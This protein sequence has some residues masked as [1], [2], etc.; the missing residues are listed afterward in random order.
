MAAEFVGVVTVSVVVTAVPEGVTVAGEKL[1]EAPVERSEQPKETAEA[2]PFAGV[3][4]TVVVLL[5]PAATVSAMG[6][7]AKE[8]SGAGKLMV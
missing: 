7:T 6:E 3:T 4:D 2:N 5:C 1:H 8:K